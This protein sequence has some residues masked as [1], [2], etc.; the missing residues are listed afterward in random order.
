MSTAIPILIL[1]HPYSTQLIHTFIM[2]GNFSAEHMCCRSGEMDA[3]LSSGMVY[4]ANP[5][6]YKKHLQSGKESIQ[7]CDSIS[8]FYAQLMILKDNTCNTYKAIEMANSSQ[9]HSD[10]TGI[11]ATT[12]CHG[13]FVPTISGQLPERG[14]VHPIKIQSSITETLMPTIRQIN[15]DYSLCKA[16]S[17]NMEAIP[18]IGDV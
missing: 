13:F 9:P 17:Y 5:N 11:R 6:L 1:T 10:V 12:C 14:K 16:L 3:P 4:M 7:V 18:C 15:M 2:D 8:T